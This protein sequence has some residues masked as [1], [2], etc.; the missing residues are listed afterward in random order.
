[1]S[2][3]REPGRKTLLAAAVTVGLALAA[4]FSACAD[5]PVGAAGHGEEAVLT[6]GVNVYLTLDR[7]TATP[8]SRVTVTG[9]V[10]TI[11]LELT[12]TGFVVDVLYDP[13]KL[14][15]IEAATLDDGVLRAINLAADP[16]LI[17]VAGAAA[18]GLRGDV[19]FAVHMEVIETGYSPS[20]KARVHELTVIENN[21]MD[22][23]PSVVVP[24]HP[25]VVGR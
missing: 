8:G 10:R 12:P 19:L 14:R 4:G 3:Y 24:P 23:T 22:V 11:D 6:S 16:G 7:E 1:M 18:D 15:P 2:S 5:E 25:V 9:K 20:L 21:F 17:K 13:E